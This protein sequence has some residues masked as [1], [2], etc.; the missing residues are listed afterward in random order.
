LTQPL[1]VRPGQDHEGL[2]VDR[3]RQRGDPRDEAPALV[4]LDGTS[5]GPRRAIS[6]SGTRSGTSP[7]ARRA[8]SLLPYCGGDVM[9]L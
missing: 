6:S 5:A 7:T 9:L 2:A 3:D 1:Q 8:V 4:Q